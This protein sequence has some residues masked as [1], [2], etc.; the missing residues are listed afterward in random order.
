MKEKNS[1]MISP[2]ETGKAKTTWP[3]N[4]VEISKRNSRKK[5]FFE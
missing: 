4:L 1:Q 3:S 5:K 2:E